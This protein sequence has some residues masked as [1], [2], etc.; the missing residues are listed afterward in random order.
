MLIAG[1]TGGMACG[2][3]F[4]A[5]A[6]REL[7]CHVIEADEVGHRVLLPE[8]EAFGPVVATFGAEIL[9]ESGQIDR[10]K[11]AAKVFGDP[12]ELARLNAL[13]HPAVRRAAISGFAEAGKQDP[14][15]VVIY[16]AAILM[17]SGAYQ[18]VQKIIVVTCTPEQQMA[19]ALARPGAVRANVEQ[20]IA[21]QM[22]MDEKKKHA[23]YLVDASMTE[24]DTLRQTRAVWE[25][26]KLQA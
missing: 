16:V 21:R 12:N 22:P 1:L 18:D 8:G 3:S 26:L 7:G 20:R 5:N 15:A 23:D 17:E 10:Q 13:V 25:N 4:V 14:H 6:F 2:K 19:R 9:D 24:Q 11:L